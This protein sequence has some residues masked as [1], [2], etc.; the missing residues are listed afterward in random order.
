MAVKAK[1]S[2][3]EKKNR[4]AKVTLEDKEAIKLAF[5]LLRAVHSPG[6]SVDMVGRHSNSIG[7]NISVHRN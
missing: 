2:T 6:A 7:A 3:S 4:W 1:F 5:Q